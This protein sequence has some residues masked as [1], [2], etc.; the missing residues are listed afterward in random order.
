MK[1][2]WICMKFIFW[3]FKY[4]FE[5]SFLNRLDLRTIFSRSLLRN[6]A[7]FFFSF[8]VV[9]KCICF[10][11]NVSQFK[12]SK[13]TDGIYHEAKGTFGI[14]PYECYM[15]GVYVQFSFILTCFFF[16]S[17]LLVV[18]H[19]LLR[20]LLRF[21]F[22]F[23]LFCAARSAILRLLLS[24]K[25]SLDERNEHNG[26]E[27]DFKSS[28]YFFLFYFFPIL[29][30][31][32]TLLSVRVSLSLV[33]TTHIQWWTYILRCTTNNIF[34]NGFSMMKRLHN[35]FRIT[36]LITF[37]MFFFVVF[38]CRF[39]FNFYKPRRWDENAMMFEK[40]IFK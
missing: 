4:N 22:F 36:R 18:F 27:N 40:F 37:G 30:P 21:Y 16:F 15:Y 6:S 3:Y 35:G 25:S 33:K 2:K 17:A 13:K 1:K 8:S 38:S 24:L 32:V 31:V 34:H 14:Y 12:H 23:S 5:F 39:T 11:L 29:I 9:R 10:Q 26:L 28:K 20:C 19:P 7:K